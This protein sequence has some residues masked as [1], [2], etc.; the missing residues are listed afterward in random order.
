MNSINE[1]TQQSLTRR[2]AVRNL[3]AIG[4]MSVAALVGNDPAFAAATR[5]T[6]RWR[7]QRDEESHDRERHPRP[8]RTR[9]PRIT[10][11]FDRATSSVMILGDRFSPNASL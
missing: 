5:R 1:S 9:Q 11:Y 4:A 10:V 2:T 7:D 8:P 3:L 6:T